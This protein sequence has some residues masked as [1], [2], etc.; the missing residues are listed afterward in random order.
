MSGGRPL[1]EEGTA[2]TL[3]LRWQLTL[4]VGAE[5]HRMCRGSH[6]A[7]EAEMA[8]ASV[9][10]LPDANPRLISSTARNKGKKKK[11]NS[12]TP[13]QLFKYPWLLPKGNGKWFRS[14]VSGKRPEVRVIISAAI[15]VLKELRHGDWELQARLEHV[16]DNVVRGVFRQA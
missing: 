6:G 12:K 1:K 3:L 2:G 14:S 13:R 15:L 5:G 10:F 7:R 16:S 8:G 9:D 4:G 11:P